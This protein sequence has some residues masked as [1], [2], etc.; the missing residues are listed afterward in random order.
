MSAIRVAVFSA[1]HWDR[2]YLGRNSTEA[3]QIDYFDEPLNA[4]TA[5]LAKGYM[6]VCVFVND[7]VDTQVLQILADINVSHVALRC[8]GFN[9]VDLD[10]AK[11]YDIKVSRVP[12]YSPEAVAEHSLALMLSLSRKIPKAYNRVR[13]D[14]FS[15]NGLL[16][17]NFSGKT[18]G[19]VGTGK[20][21]S[22]LARILHGMGMQVLCYDPAE[23]PLLQD[24]PVRYVPLNT[25]TEQSDVI[26]LHCPLNNE[27]QHLINHDTIA[28]M[29]RGVM[30]IN[31]SRGA[32]VDTP[33]IIDG[34]KSGH[35]GYLGLD[36][37]EMESELFFQDHSCDIIQDD[38]FQRLMTFPNVII[39]GHQGF[40]TAEAIQEIACSTLASV[41]QAHQGFTDPDAF[42][43]AG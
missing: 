39:T 5:A 37:Y 11:A 2:E 40:F 31:T 8:A 30:L 36:V 7:V 13:D 4:H 18:V 21:G 12:A 42:L 15:L 22:A 20:I 9:N 38:V 29:K 32:L 35:I 6:S 33:A 27:T 3:Y 16:G 24:I 41:K 26:S 1:T 28:K 14:N 19:I 25:L 43:V 17:F 34:L 23:N 10:A